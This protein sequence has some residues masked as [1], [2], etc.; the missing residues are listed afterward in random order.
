MTR[1]RG[2]SVKGRN[3]EQE[4]MHA[5]V[6]RKLASEDRKNLRKERDSWR[7]GKQKY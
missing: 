1:E 4:K 6:V 5:I 3:T 7:E 2:P